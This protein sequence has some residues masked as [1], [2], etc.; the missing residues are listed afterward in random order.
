MRASALAMRS[1]ST[2]NGAGKVRRHELDW[3]RTAAVF[4]LIP[5]HTAIIFTTG[6]FDYIRNAQS[7]A[8]MDALTSFVSI[9]GIPVLFLV[10]GGASRFALAARSAR[11]FLDERVMR[12]LIP[13][14]FGML[15]IVPLQIYIGKLSAPTPP[16]LP[17]FYLGFLLTLVGVLAGHFPPGP[18][19]IG[20]LW[21][22]PPLMAFSAL[23]L[24]FAAA[25]RTAHGQR[26][27]RWLA[28]ASH[29]VAPLALLG[30][31]FAVIQLVIV[32]SDWLFP[33]LATSF[34][35]N[36]IGVAAYLVF[37]F[38]GYLLYLD[39]RLLSGIRRDTCSALA[40]GVGAWLWIAFITPAWWQSGAPA[41]A[42]LM[43]AL[44]RGY[45]SWWW[46]MGILGLALRY[47]QFTTPVVEYLSRAAYPVYIIHMPI[48]SFVGLWI[49]RLDLN[50][51]LKFGIITVLALAA[52]LAFYDLLIRRVGALRMLFGLPPD[53]QPHEPPRHNGFGVIRRVKPDRTLWRAVRAR[54]AARDR[55]H[56]AASPIAR[57]PGVRGLARRGLLY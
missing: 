17:A 50:I 34:A 12:L 56:A 8:V 51:W 22:I 47:L 10:A 32:V 35:T 13:F 9:W 37:F 52:S 28:G 53:K 40:L 20:H 45:C 1:T 39:D 25:L 27:L 24:P 15:L 54:A 55:S 30:L 44:N 3:L 49:V 2:T 43:V 57:P 11:Q 29:G 5:F 33:S 7:S 4:G 19:W 46:V 23:A 41:P 16:A 31:P 42:G 21:F 38:Y 26:A 14:L 36:A 48:L 6:S 18:E